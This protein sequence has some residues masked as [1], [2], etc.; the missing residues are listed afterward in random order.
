LVVVIATAP[1]GAWCW[2]EQVRDAL[3]DLKTLV[4]EASNAGRT[5]IDPELLAT[6]TGLIRSA[7]VI[8]VAATGRRRSA[9]EA[10]HHALARRI[11]H[12]Q[13]DYLRFAIDFRVPFDN[14]A[15]ER[16]IRM[17]RLREKVSG[18]TRT[19]AG[20]E[21]FAAIRSYL[22]TAAKHGIGFLH[23]LTELVAGRPW[24]PIAP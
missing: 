13:A 22:A 23:A 10:K 16:E 14:N 24:L 18:C 2:A 9:I 21:H 5:V 11:L 1:Q 4:A 17:V 6:H 3:L 8:A 7:A 15:A 20:A 12:R 19:L